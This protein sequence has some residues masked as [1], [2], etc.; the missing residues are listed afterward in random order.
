MYQILS[1]T[2]LEQFK[3]NTL[4]YIVVYQKPKTN[5]SNSHHGVDKKWIRVLYKVVR[6]SGGFFACK[7]MLINSRFIFDILF[8]IPK[9]W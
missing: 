5:F 7:L 6:P 2:V 4:L 1:K 8:S 9:C 3:E